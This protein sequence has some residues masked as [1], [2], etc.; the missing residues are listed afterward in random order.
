MKKK[1]IISIVVLLVVVFGVF[2][3]TKFA[4]AEGNSGEETLVVSHELGET[5]VNKNP[6][7]V[8]VFDY[9]ILDSLDKLE[10]EGIVGLVQDGLPE[11]LSKFESE[12]YS[13]VGSLKEPNMEKIFELTPDLII[14]SGRQADYYEELSKIAPTIHLGVNNENYL[15]SFSDNMNKLG[16]IFGK[17]KAV[18][19]VLTAITEAIEELNAKVTEKNVNGLIT[20]ANDGSFSV[21]GAESRF[22]IIHNSFGVTPVDETIEA[23]THGQKASF[24]YIVEKNPQ[25]LF[26]VDRAAIVGGTTSA[27]ELFENELMKKTDVY[28]NDNIVYLNPNIWYTATG[29]FTSTMIMVEEIDNAIK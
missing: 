15:E 17:E 27:K 7:R 3:I 11:H 14:I 29:G 28:K 10:V 23:S 18:E 19:K 13:S 25:Y 16:E 24:E 9:G 4:G 6:K 26:V 8:V 12:D 2:V 21:Y 20:L 5:T 22:G 1:T